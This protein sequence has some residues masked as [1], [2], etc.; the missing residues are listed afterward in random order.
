MLH[1]PVS[2]GLFTPGNIV[3]SASTGIYGGD[4]SMASIKWPS[5]SAN[6]LLVRAQQDDRL[7]YSENPD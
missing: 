7:R 6:D 4:L 2:N 1:V 5:W 3:G